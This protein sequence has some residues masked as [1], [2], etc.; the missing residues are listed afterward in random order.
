MVRRCAHPALAVI[1]CRT[2]RLERCADRAS[3]L[4]PPTCAGAR[5][6]DAAVRRADRGMPAPDRRGA[7][8]T[9]PGTSA[10]ARRFVHGDHRTCPCTTRASY[11][12]RRALTSIQTADMVVH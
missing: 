2:Q 1:D 5:P 6:T 11:R 8:S 12:E 3:W 7:R 4:L 9:A 10:S